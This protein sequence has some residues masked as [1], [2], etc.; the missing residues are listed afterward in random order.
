MSNY[1]LCGPAF[2]G[3]C[4]PVE[5]KTVTEANILC[6]GTRVKSQE[7]ILEVEETPDAFPGYHSYRITTENSI[8]A[9]I[10]TA[11]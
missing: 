7:K 1:Y 2:R 8:Y 6:N 10:L 11:N 5:G 9:V 4:P 3:W